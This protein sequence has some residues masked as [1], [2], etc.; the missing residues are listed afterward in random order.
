MSSNDPLPKILTE[1]LISNNR[2][3]ALTRVNTHNVSIQKVSGSQ[4]YMRDTWQENA[5]LN[6]II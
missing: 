6:L 4:L 5:F 1:L 3:R 2:A